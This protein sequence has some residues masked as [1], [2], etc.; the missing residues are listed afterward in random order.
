MVQTG[1]GV[2]LSIELYI[3]N[4]NLRLYTIYVHKDEV[5]GYLICIMSMSLCTFLVQHIKEL[6]SERRI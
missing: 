2:A 6:R 5:M 1:V 3:L 4:A